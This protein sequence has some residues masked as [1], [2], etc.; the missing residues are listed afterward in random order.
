MQQKRRDRTLLKTNDRISGT[1]LHAPGSMDTSAD[2]HKTVF[3]GDIN[4]EWFHRK[5]GSRVKR[6]R[7][8]YAADIEYEGKDGSLKIMGLYK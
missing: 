1:R 8:M 3:H 5:P 4:L 2:S 7:A 6:V